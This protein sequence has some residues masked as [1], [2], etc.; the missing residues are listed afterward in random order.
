MTFFCG[1]CGPAHHHRETGHQTKLLSEDPKQC[2]CPQ[3][4]AAVEEL[5]LWL[6]PTHPF[7]RLGPSY[8]GGPVPMDDHWK[9]V[10]GQIPCSHVAH[11]KLKYDFIWG[12]R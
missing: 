10:V 9:G 3:G 5:G 8:L 11:F 2:H 12:V 6:P 7:P 4:A 1:F